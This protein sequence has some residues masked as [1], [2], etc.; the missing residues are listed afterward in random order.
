MIEIVLKILFV[1]L[2]SVAAGMIGFV[3]YRIGHKDG[4]K[5]KEKEIKSHKDTITE[6][7]TKLQV[8]EKKIKSLQEQLNEYTFRP[9]VTEI[10]VERPEVVELKTIK[11]VSENQ[12]MWMGDDA[13]KLIKDEMEKDLIGQIM[14]RTNIYEEKDIVQMRTIYTATIR[15]LV[16]R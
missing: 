5:L 12:K 8:A 3:S 1:V 13:E 4:L 14:D 6:L 7:S 10:R 16:R 15:I 9:P 11:M 2:S